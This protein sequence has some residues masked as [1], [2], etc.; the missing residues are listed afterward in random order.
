MVSGESTKECLSFGLARLC[1]LASWREIAFSRR[2]VR[3]KAQSSKKKTRKVSNNHTNDFDF[4]RTYDVL[5][6]VI[7]PTIDIHFR[8]EYR[9]PV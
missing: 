3:A 7:T 5:T 8:Q 2:K 9:A 6:T 4:N 1:D